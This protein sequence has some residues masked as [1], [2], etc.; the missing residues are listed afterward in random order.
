MVTDLWVGKGT[1]A[2]GGTVPESLAT[3]GLRGPPTRLAEGRPNCSTA[4]SRGQSSKDFQAPAEVPWEPNTGLGSLSELCQEGNDGQTAWERN[5]GV[6]LQCLQARAGWALWGSITT[7]WLFL[8]SHATLSL[9]SLL[10]FLLF[11]TLL[12]TGPRTSLL[13][14]KQPTNELYPCLCVLLLF[15]GEYT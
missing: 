13:L 14:G 10:A 12:G 8:G 3:E 2:G 11:A 6:C 1:R 15:Y 4:G 9:F 5:S 7:S